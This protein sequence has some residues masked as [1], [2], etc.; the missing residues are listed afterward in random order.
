MLT[1]I[2]TRW[3]GAVEVVYLMSRVTF[4]KIQQ[5]IMSPN[6]SNRQVK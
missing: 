5:F 2:A 1:S 4:R 6:V 3:G